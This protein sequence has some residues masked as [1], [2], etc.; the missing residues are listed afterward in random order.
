M[1]VSHLCPASMRWQSRLFNSFDV[2]EKDADDYIKDCEKINRLIVAL[3]GS[4]YKTERSYNITPLSDAENF[5]HPI[6][7][8][9]G[10]PEEFWA[11]FKKSKYTDLALDINSFGDSQRGDN[12]LE[13]KMYS[14]FSFISQHKKDIIK[15]GKRIWLL[16]FTQPHEV[17]R[18]GEEVYGCVD[19]VVIKEAF[20]RQPLRD[21]FYTSL[22]EGY[23]SDTAVPLG[24]YE[25]IRMFKNWI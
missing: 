7:L 8:L 22:H 20:W 10:D 12:E 19:D 5:E 25:S 17:K 2:V 11:S 6:V 23:P 14:R 24:V 9:E 18:Y 13:K 16:G 15:S 4:S 21:E 3:P 1:L